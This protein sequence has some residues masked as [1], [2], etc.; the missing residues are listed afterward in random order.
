VAKNDLPDRL[1]AFVI[2]V[3]KLLRKL[4]N[5]EEYKVIKYQLTKSA[6][7]SGA[8]YEEA[9]VPPQKQI[10]TIKFIFR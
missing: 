9:Q 3:I 7:S 1:L 5:T 4:P 6:T 8:N 2:R 10:S